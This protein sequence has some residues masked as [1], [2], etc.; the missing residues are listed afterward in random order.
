MG[1]R[2]ENQPQILSRYGGQIGVR[3]GTTFMRDSKTFRLLR[4]SDVRA[5]FTAK[6]TKYERASKDSETHLRMSRCTGDTS[7]VISMW[8]SFFCAPDRGRASWWAAGRRGKAAAGATGGGRIMEGTGWRWEGGGW[9]V[10]DGGSRGGGWRMVG[11]GVEGGGWRVAEEMEDGE[12][13][14]ARARTAHVGAAPVRPA[15]T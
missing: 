9:W 7:A 8:W 10:E 12:E 4:T 2:R 11:R 1:G 14:K 13:R 6:S 15:Q 3:H 5:K